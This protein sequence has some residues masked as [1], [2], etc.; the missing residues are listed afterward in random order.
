MFTLIY[1]QTTGVIR[2]RGKMKEDF[3]KC[4]GSPRQHG[5]RDDEKNKSNPNVGETR[6]GKYITALIRFNAEN[7]FIFHQIISH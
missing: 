7:K 5:K 3:I 2:E 6:V 1:S 4:L